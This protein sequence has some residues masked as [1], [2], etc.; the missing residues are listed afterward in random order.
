MSQSD[1]QTLETSSASV[2]CTTQEDIQTAIEQL[3]LAGK[4]LFLHGAIKS[5]GHLVGGPDS[6]FTPLLQAGC[7][8]VMPSFTYG[9]ICNP[10]D[11]WHLDNIGHRG[12][13]LF[14]QPMPYSVSA[15]TIEKDMGAL[16]KA[17]LHHPER[18]RSSHPINSF[19][20]VGPRAKEIVNAQTYQNVYGLYQVDEE[21]LVVTMGVGL[22]SVTPIHF[23]EQLAG[24]ALF[25]R[26]A[27]IHTAEGQHEVQVAIGSCSNGFERLAPAIKDLA[28]Q[29]KAGQSVWHVY[30]LAQLVARC[31]QQ[32][33]N[34]PN[35]THCPDD[36]CIRCQDAIASQS[37]VTP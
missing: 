30:P 6:L 4:T 29:T 13:W 21:A 18:R 8:L 1:S 17:L 16:A 9:P 2:S 27:Q 10:P 5:F 32:I 31:Q 37:T 24:R 20:A 25:Q 14:D 15:N 19:T 36:S 7:T 26:W 35:I 34:Q 3:Q 23:A 28:Q 22:T 33:V 11:G 12:P